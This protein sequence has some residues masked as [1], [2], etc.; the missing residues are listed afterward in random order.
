MMK[1]VLI[2]TDLEHARNLAMALVDKGAFV[3]FQP[4][5]VEN[6]EASVVFNEAD[7]PLLM[8]MTPIYEHADNTV[9]L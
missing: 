7:M 5:S 3:E 9:G 4:P 2:N 8:G 6:G 1:T